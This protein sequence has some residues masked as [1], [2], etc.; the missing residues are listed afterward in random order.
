VVVAALLLAAAL[1]QT[2]PAWREAQLQ[3]FDLAWSTINDT[4][5]DREFGG[6]DWAAAR[7]ELRPRVEGAASA[8]AAREVI[9]ELLGRMGRSHFGLLSDPPAGEEGGG[10]AAAPFDVRVI[11]GRAIVTRVDDGPSTRMAD[12]RP[13]DEV[14]AVDGR[15]VGEWI[16]A[17]EGATDRARSLSAWQRISR[18]LHGA[19]GSSVALR[20]RAPGGSERRAVV[21]RRIPPGQPVRFGNLPELRVAVDEEELRTSAGRRAGRIAFSVWMPAIDAPVAAAIDRFRDHDGLMLDL[22]GNPGGLAE[23]LRGISG[24]VIDTPDLLGT[25]RLRATTLTFT[26][27]PR[28]STPDGRSV[29]P[30]SGPVA[31]LVDELTGSTSECFAGALQSLGRATVVGRRTMGQALPALTRQLPSG[32]VLMYV[33]GDFVTSTGQPV[34][35]D[36]VRPDVQVPFSREALAKG[37]DPVVEAAL[38]WLDEVR[39]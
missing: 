17:A 32:D 10:P 25:M 34:E 12:V 1:A 31:I 3:S 22:R 2:S 35:G 11:E 28:R 37:R 18:A 36:G 5:Y 33:I 27:N 29:R 7:A 20:L 19:G 21:T 4:Y 24:H 26:V 6:V 14:V 9:R 16:A 23:M 8:D 30:F 13:G 15:Q 38:K 39:R